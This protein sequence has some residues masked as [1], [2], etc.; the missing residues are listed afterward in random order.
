L[1]A[2]WETDDAELLKFGETLTGDP[3][4]SLKQCFRKV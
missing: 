3:E 1:S 2:R 4:P